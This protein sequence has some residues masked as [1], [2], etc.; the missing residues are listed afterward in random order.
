MY[1]IWLICH[2]LFRHPDVDDI[3]KSFHKTTRRLDKLADR[4]ADYSVRTEATISGK[5]KELV[6]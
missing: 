1:T 5:I 3:V 4:L 6:G 2:W